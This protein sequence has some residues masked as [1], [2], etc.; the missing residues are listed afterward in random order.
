MSRKGERSDTSSD[1]SNVPC[2]EKVCLKEQ[3]KP[4]L[5]DDLNYSEPPLTSTTL[6]GRS[7]LGACVCVLTF[8]GKR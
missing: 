1:D 3:E 4:C 7:G 8:L 2:S 5:F 6:V